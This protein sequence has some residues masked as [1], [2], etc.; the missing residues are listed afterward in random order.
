VLCTDSNEY[1]TWA[2]LNKRVK[3]WCSIRTWYKW[4]DL[5]RYIL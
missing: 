4:Y 2:A 5:F 1:I 3:P